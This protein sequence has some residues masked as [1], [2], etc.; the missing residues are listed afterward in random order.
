MLCL[1]FYAQFEV[2]Q[3]NCHDLLQLDDMALD[4]LLQDLDAQEEALYQL[5][6]SFFPYLEIE[7]G[8]T[9][10]ARGVVWGEH[11]KPHPTG[12]SFSQFCE[13]YR[14]WKASRSGTLHLEQEPG[15]KLFMDDTGENSRLLI[16]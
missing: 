10:V 15:D 8:R 3:L 11:R 7:L 5:L 13:H 12:Y 16:R 6:T 9:G 4:A 2:K 14:D 1:L